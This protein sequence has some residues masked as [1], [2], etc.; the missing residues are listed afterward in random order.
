MEDHYPN[1]TADYSDDSLV[2]MDSMPEVFAVRLVGRMTNSRWNPHKDF[3]ANGYMRGAL[4]RGAARSGYYYTNIS[5][6]AGSISIVV[7]NGSF[8]E[9]LTPLEVAR[10]LGFERELAEPYTMEL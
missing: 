9:R 10:T 1:G 5:E 6:D 8:V 2:S 4:K 3:H 7:P